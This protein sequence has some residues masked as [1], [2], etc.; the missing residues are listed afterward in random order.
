MTKEEHKEL[1]EVIKIGNATLSRMED[2]IV[3][4]AALKDEIQTAITLLQ[5]SRGIPTGT[6]APSKPVESGQTVLENEWELNVQPKDKTKEVYDIIRVRAEQ[7][8]KSE[9][10][11][12]LFHQIMKYKASTG[13]FG[14]GVNMDGIDYFM[15]ASEYKGFKQIFRRKQT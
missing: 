2:H 14:M 6:T 11:N 5:E 12:T 1:L 10:I 13:N 15:W 4:I 8:F 7:T 9:D 3:R